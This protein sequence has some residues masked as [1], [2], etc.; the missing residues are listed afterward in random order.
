M[1]HQLS[2]PRTTFDSDKTEI[3]NGPLES[4]HFDQEVISCGKL[5]SSR[6]GDPIR[7]AAMEGKSGDDLNV[8]KAF[9]G[10]TRWWW[11]LE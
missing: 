3:S 6:E 4:D 5:P 11:R 1:L 2:I 10:G 8:G 9:S 7:P